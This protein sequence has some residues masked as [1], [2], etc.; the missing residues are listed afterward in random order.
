MQNGIP[1]WYFHEHCGEHQGY[2]IDS[3]DPTGVIGAM[4][5]PARV[6]GCV[7]YPASELDRAGH[8]QTY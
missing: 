8:C 7:V 6:V 1:Y 5:S 3:V 2:R 4:I